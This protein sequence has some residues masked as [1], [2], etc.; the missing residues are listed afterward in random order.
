MVNIIDYA[1]WFDFVGW[2]KRT[3]WCDKTKCGT[4]VGEVFGVEQAGIYVYRSIEKKSRV[5]I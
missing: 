5:K 2:Y 3:G 4:I 1:K